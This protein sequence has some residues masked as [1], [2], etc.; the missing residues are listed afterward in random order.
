LRSKGSTSDEWEMMRKLTTNLIWSSIPSASEADVQKKFSIIPKLIDLL[1]ANLFHLDTDEEKEKVVAPL[2][3]IFYQILKQE[4]PTLVMAQPLES[5]KLTDEATVSV[6]KGLIKKVSQFKRGSWLIWQEKDKT[7]RCMLASVM[8]ELEEVLFVNR[9]GSKALQAS[10]ERLAY[11][12]SIKEASLLPNERLFSIV[13]L[14]FTKQLVQNYFTKEDADAAEAENELAKIEQEKQARKQA[15]EQAKKE[16]LAIEKA[17]K[18]AEEKA[19]QEQKQR[20]E[21]ERLSALEAE[22]KEQS[23]KEQQAREMLNSINLGDWVEMEKNA[24]VIQCKLSLK[25]KSSDKFIFT[26]KNGLKTGEYRGASEL[27][28]MILKKRFRIL[29]NENQGDNSLTRIIGS[30]RGD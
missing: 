7:I 30:I 13:Y 19:L 29:S 26:D 25:M 17:Q 28:P 1:K 22:E 16:A 6:S 15:S 21:Q 3:S 23:E 27:I 20:E 14:E 8:P 10:L 5:Q 18:E 12:Y 11:K 4:I 24:A 2:D 9:A